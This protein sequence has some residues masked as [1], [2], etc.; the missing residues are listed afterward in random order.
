MVCSD[1]CQV[2]PKPLPS[3][4][5]SLL[6]ASLLPFYPPPELLIGQM[7]YQPAPSDQQESSSPGRPTASLAAGKS[8]TIKSR[9]LK[10]SRTNID[11][12]TDT[13]TSFYKY[14][15]DA[16]LPDDHAP[17]CG[18]C[19]AWAS[20]TSRRP[21]CH[22]A[23]ADFLLCGCRAGVGVSIQHFLFIIHCVAAC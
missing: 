2:K 8:I 14:L 9:T 13:Y 12:I 6:D 15:H 3:L 21:R 19:F 1:C 5:G 17:V 7:N 4:M 11:L 22:K 23:A 18:L 20:L 10:P 16:I